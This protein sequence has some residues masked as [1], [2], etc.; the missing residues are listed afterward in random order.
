MVVPSFL[1]KLDDIQERHD[2]QYGMVLEGRK[3]KAPQRLGYA[4]GVPNGGASATQPGDRSEER[5][6]RERV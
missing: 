4:E 6:C 1:A 5:R 3:P 2:S